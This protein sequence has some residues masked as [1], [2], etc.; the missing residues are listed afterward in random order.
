MRYKS[1]FSSSILLL[2]I[3]LLVIPVIISI[4]KNK[5]VLEVSRDSFNVDLSL[6]LIF[7]QELQ[8]LPSLCT[9]RDTGLETAFD[10]PG[11]IIGNFDSDSEVEIFM[12]NNDTSRL[13][14]YDPWED[15]VKVNI[16]IPV[17]FPRQR[18]VLEAADLTGDSIDEV[19]IFDST[20]NGVFVLNSNGNTIWT[21]PGWD[22]SYKINYI[23]S[24]DMDGDSLNDLI[25]CSSQGDLVVYRGYNGDELFRIGGITTLG[26]DVSDAHPTSGLEI[27]AGGSYGWPL[28]LLSATA[29]VLQDLNEQGDDFFGRGVAST[30]FGNY[31]GDVYDDIVYSHYSRYEDTSSMGNIVLLDSVT[32]D[33]V[34]KYLN[35]THDCDIMLPSKGEEQYLYTVN[36]D[37][38]IKFT[39]FSM[40]QSTPVFNVSIPVGSVYRQ[41]I[42]DVNFIESNKSIVL[43]SWNVGSKEFTT[44]ILDPDNGTVIQTLDGEAF[45]KDV[46]SDGIDDL[47]LLHDNYIRVY[48]S[49]SSMIPNTP[50]NV[51]AQA[52][53]QAIYLDWDIVSSNV[54]EYRIYRSN[55]SGS[56]FAQIGISVTNAY[57]DTTVTND[58]TYYYK[59]SALNTLG[60]GNT[61][62][63]IGPVIPILPEFDL[64]SIQALQ[65]ASLAMIT[66]IIILKKRKD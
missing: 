58:L 43:S 7:E 25:I 65:F 42:Q 27:S 24:A 35:M 16:S 37:R 31:S 2:L 17:N 9:S 61:S 47:I 14:I 55:I 48:S 62:L 50:E 30:C 11:W 4:P 29:G 64:I 12:L 21:D 34:W 52:G 26:L 32:G 15:I 44:L 18:P 39:D 49:D 10:M 38:F 59:V 56:G 40:N 23:R 20:D 63:E 19:I 54:N 1:L 22:Y 36:Y 45:V 51:Q 46:S 66:S 6:P 53:D 33:V 60:E 13:Y 5:S 57:N 41:F 8:V 3:I 28:Y